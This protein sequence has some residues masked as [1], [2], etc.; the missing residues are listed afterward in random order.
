VITARTHQHITHFVVPVAHDAGDALLQRSQVIYG[1][2]ID[3]GAHNDGQPG[4]RSLAHLH[5]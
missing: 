4:Q 1:L 3:L 5:G 2:V